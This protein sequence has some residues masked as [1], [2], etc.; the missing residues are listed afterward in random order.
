MDPLSPQDRAALLGIARAAVRHHLGLGSAPPLPSSGP[1][2][3]PRGAF[4]TLRVERALRGCIGSFEPKGTL[5][6][7]V[8]AVAVSAASEDP[9]FPPVRREEADD[10]GY[11]VSALGPRTPLRDPSEIEI[12]TH[13][14]LVK[15]GWHRG[16]LLPAVAVERGFDAVAFL[17]HT[18][19]K[20]GLRP[21]AWRDPE[22][23]VEIYTAEEFGDAGED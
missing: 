2:A 22:A 9:R 11:C 6:G 20:A 8:A 23:T 14:L 5:A 19:L 16:T 18:C 1:L 13:G 17:R 4:V 7:T 10:L 3:V 21:D 15:K 12:G